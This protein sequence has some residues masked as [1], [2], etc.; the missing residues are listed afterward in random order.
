[1]AQAPQRSST[2]FVRVLRG[3]IAGI[4]KLLLPPR[5]SRGISLVVRNKV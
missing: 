4:V 2:E 5:Q 3:A 1:L